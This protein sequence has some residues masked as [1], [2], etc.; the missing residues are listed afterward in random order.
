MQHFAS[1]ICASPVRG[2]MSQSMDV[3]YNQF[4]GS[5]NALLGN[6][7]YIVSFQADGNM[8][9]GPLPANM[10]SLGIMVRLQIARHF[11]PLLRLHSVHAMGLPEKMSGS[12]FEWSSPCHVYLCFAFRLTGLQCLMPIT[13]KH[14]YASST[15]IDVTMRPVQV[16]C[17]IEFWRPQCL[18]ALPVLQ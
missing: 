10:A 7:E 4:S 17:C 14:E 15:S 11:V 2:C 8:L 1:H 3:G 16:A 13:T 5:F 6:C 9:S 18:N 12:S